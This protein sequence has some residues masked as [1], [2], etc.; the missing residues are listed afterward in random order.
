MLTSKM[1]SWQI[2]TARTPKGYSPKDVFLRFKIQLNRNIQTCHLKTHVTDRLDRVH[3]CVCPG[4][5]VGVSGDKEAPQSYC[6][7]HCFSP[8]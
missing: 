1:E 8:S 6:S 3:V 2:L 4:Q 5:G 7:K